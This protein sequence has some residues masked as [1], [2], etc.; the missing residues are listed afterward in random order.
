MGGRCYER[1]L[2]PVKS[3]S[4]PFPTR[5]S[6]WRCVP[7]P[8]LCQAYDGQSLGR[9]ALTQEDLN[10][11]RGFILDLVK[12]RVKY[13]EFVSRVPQHDVLSS[14]RCRRSLSIETPRGRDEND[15]IGFRHAQAKAIATASRRSIR[16]SHWSRE[17]GVLR[18]AVPG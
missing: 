16:C 1:A 8:P 13:S 5:Q 2:H 3:G 15:E 10:A 18:R 9:K 4:C 12:A 14:G 17:N 11:R 6:L 7:V